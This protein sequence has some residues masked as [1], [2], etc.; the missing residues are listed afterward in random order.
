MEWILKYERE[1]EHRIGAVRT[2]QLYLRRELLTVHQVQREWDIR[3]ILVVLENARGIENCLKIELSG[4][5]I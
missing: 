4:P 2:V 1:M 3:F 5:N